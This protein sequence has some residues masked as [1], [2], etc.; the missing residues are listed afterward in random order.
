[1]LD[2]MCRLSILILVFLMATNRSQVNAENKSAPHT[3]NLTSAFPSILQLKNLKDWQRFEGTILFATSVRLVRTKGGNVLPELASSWTVSRDQRTY[4]FRLNPNAKFSDG[5]PI[6][7]EDVLFNFKRHL[8]LEGQF[9]KPLSDALAN[10]KPF[11]SISDNVEGFKTP[12]KHTFVIEL[13]KPLPALFDYIGMLSFGILKASDVDLSRDRVL[14]GHAA[15]GPY[16]IQV[17]EKESVQ[18]VRLKSHWLFDVSTLPQKVVI[19]PEIH[20]KSNLDRLKLG[21]IDY[22]HSQKS[23]LELE[24]FGSEKFERVEAGVSHLILSADFKGPTLRHEKTIAGLLAR[25]LD[26]SILAELLSQRHDLLFTPSSEITGGLKQ[27]EVGYT[28]NKLKELKKLKLVLSALKS[29]GR[30]SRITLAFAQNNPVQENI[31]R[32]IQEYFKGL[33]VEIRIKAIKFADI[34]ETSRNGDFDFSIQSE[35]FDSHKPSLVIP[36]LINADARYTN[37]PADHEIFE[38]IKKPSFAKDFD[39]HVSI[40][41]EFNDLMY[42]QGIVVPLF[43]DHTLMLF[44]KRFDTTH[45]GKFDYVWHPQ[46]L[47]LR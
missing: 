6:T 41:R 34:L 26:R 25:T 40:L 38:L 8:L 2:K 4:T 45:V 31:A 28:Y 5:T 32:V 37:L 35:T 33:S 3:L 42:K 44:S 46:D 24:D 23:S 1:M 10:F 18:L 19:E 47:R 22:W 36:F 13:S 14:V 21:K 12:N 9:A 20:S 30:E 17:F 27:A 7:S 43:M 15:S 39:E 29:R 16:Q 11:N